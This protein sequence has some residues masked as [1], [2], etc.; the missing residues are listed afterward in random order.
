MTFWAI[1]TLAATAI[2]TIYLVLYLLEGK[3]FRRLVAEYEASRKAEKEAW[4][5]VH[6]EYEKAKRNAQ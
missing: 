4:A 6:E 1:M 3:R 5:K 2:A